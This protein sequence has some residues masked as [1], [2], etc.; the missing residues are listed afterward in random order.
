MRRTP[1]WE[2]PGLLRSGQPPLGRPARQLVAGGKLELAQHRRDVALHGLDRR[3]RA[4][5]RS[6]CRY[7]RGRSGGGPR[8]RAGVSWSSSGSKVWRPD[9]RGRGPRRRRGRSWPAGARR[10]RPR[11]RPGTPRPPVRR[12]RSSWSRSPRAPA[13][14]TAITSS[15]A[16]EADRAR[17]R[18]CGWAAFVAVTTSWPPPP[19]RCTSSRTTSGTRSAM[20]V[21]A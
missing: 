1:A 19:G 21:I 9:R 2:R 15:G 8:A 13:R 3:C 11:P 6:P 14:I 5:A 4:R 16:S 12:R 20:R 18:T 10:P 7:S 17:K